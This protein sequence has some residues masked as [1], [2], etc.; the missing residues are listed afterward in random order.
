MT[1]ICLNLSTFDNI[2]LSK[3]NLFA[4]LTS[5]RVYIYTDR[6]SS[7]WWHSLN[8]SVYDSPRV[9]WSPTI[10]NAHTFGVIFIMLNLRKQIL[11]PM[12]LTLPFKK[13][14]NLSFDRWYR[15]SQRLK[16]KLHNEMFDFN[17]DFILNQFLWKKTI[18]LQLKW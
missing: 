12:D 8:S 4:K 16:N 5:T 9:Q 13:Q 10:I 17:L 14:S 15:F 18:L 1:F 7:T 11:F 3:L 6:F 2:H